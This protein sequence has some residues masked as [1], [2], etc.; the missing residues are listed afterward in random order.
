MFN[1][2]RLAVLFLV[3]YILYKVFKGLFLST[4]RKAGN[5]SLEKNA[6]RGEELVEDPHCHRY[7]PMSQAHRASVDGEDLFFCSRE[8]S[9]QYKINKDLN[10]DRR[11]T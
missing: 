9:E 6:A 4:D 2:I 5:P 11:T 1:L 10:E 7:L 8:C 3:I